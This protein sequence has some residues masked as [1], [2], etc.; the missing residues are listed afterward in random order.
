[1][2]V[3]LLVQLL[4]L[5]V[6]LNIANA[7]TVQVN[8][9]SEIASLP[10]HDLILWQDS[11]NP[12]VPIVFGTQKT[13]PGLT[14][15]K[16]EY[17]ILSPQYLMLL[18]KDRSPGCEVTPQNLHGCGFD[19]DLVLSTDLSGGPIVIQFKYPVRAVGTDIQSF[20]FDDR[21]YKVSMTIHYADR[22][23]K[24]FESS[25]NTQRSGNELA[26]FIGVKSDAANIVKV[27][28]SVPRLEAYPYYKLPA[29]NGRFDLVIS[30]I[31]LAY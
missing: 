29:E 14:I 6:T 28:F 30:Q 27:E 19:Y 2:N 20:S 3:L 18:S 23:Q 11:F 17:S 10:R 16:K 12:D 1:M 24:T 7:K 4:S 22:S 31:E 25:G 8:Q 21:A 15:G 5:V 13:L 26:P 9:R